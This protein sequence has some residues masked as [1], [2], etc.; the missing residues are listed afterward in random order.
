MPLLRGDRRVCPIDIPPDIW[1][2]NSA[3]H[4]IIECHVPL[5]CG[6]YQLFVGLHLCVVWVS[7]YLGNLGPDHNFLD[8]LLPLLG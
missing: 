1:L 7:I 2:A 8:G 5:G 6:P 3:L 4:D